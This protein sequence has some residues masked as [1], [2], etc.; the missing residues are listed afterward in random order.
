MNDDEEHGGGI[1][2]VRPTFNPISNI[3]NQRRLVARFHMRR[4][5]WVN[6]QIHV[7]DKEVEDSDNQTI[8]EMTNTN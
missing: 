7:V 4:S 3:R 8:E 1:G 5:T 6:M 2:P